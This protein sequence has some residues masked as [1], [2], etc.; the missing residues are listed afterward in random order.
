MG[1]LVHLGSH[2]TPCPGTPSLGYEKKRQIPC[3]GTELNK[4]HTISNR[5]NLEEDTDTLHRTGTATDAH[6]QCS[7]EDKS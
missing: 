6:W 4:D 1:V 5:D 7:V 3:R 2:G